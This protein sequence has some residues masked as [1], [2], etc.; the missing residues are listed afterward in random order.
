MPQRPI[1]G[2]FQKLDNV[3]GRRETQN[4][5]GPPSG[6]PRAATGNV[7]GILPHTKDPPDRYGPHSSNEEQ[8][9]GRDR[10][11]SGVPC[12]MHTAGGAPEMEP[13]NTGCWTDNVQ[14]E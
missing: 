2:S 6:G 4:V 5:G 8:E 7:E 9:T 10:S 11:P 1:T 12:S 13:N 3:V 14:N